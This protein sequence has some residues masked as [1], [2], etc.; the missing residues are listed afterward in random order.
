MSKAAKNLQQTLAGVRIL[1]VDDDE[2]VRDFVGETLT[3]A[4]A[5]VQLAADGIEAFDLLETAP[6]DVVVSDVRMPRCDGLQ[7][8]HK[9]QDKRRNG[10][11]FIVMT[12]FFDVPVSEILHLGGNEVLSK[13]FDGGDVIRSV[14][15]FLRATGWVAKPKSP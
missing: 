15:G 14:Q 12:G 10:L 6:F 11:G 1:V 2:D 3:T 4:G 13:P 8:M 5:S 9:L 7:L